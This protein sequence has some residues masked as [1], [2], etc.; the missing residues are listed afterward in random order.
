VKQLGA[1]VLVLALAPQAPPGHARKIVLIAGPLDSHPQDT[2]E[3]ERTI[4]LL[5]HCMESS[6]VFRGVRVDLVFGGWPSDPAA[7][8][9]AD[10]ILLTSGGCDRKLEDHPLY[11]GDHLQCLERQ[12]KRGCGIIFLHW[13]TFH[14]SQHHDLITEA[15]GGYF[16]FETGPP[17][18]R[19][20]SR[21][22]TRDW[23][24]TIGAPDHPIS[25]GVKPFALKE[26][27]YYRLRFRDE[28]PRLRF[29]LLKDGGEPRSSA[30]GWA[31]ERKDGGRG[32]GFTG[33]H[34][35]ANWW[36]P[37]FRRL[38]LNA[39]AWTAKI[40]VPAGG[41][42]SALEMPARARIVTGHHHPAHDWKATTAALI[43]VLEQDPR[44]RLEVTEDPEDLAGARLNGVDLVVL[45][46][47]NWEKPG[48]SNAAKD[49]FLNYL[50]RGGGLVVM[51]GANGA[52][53]GS[54]VPPESDWE[55]YRT[56]IVRRAWVS[57]KSG[58]D[59]YGPFRVE[60]SPAPHGITA[61][62]S[63]FDTLDELY[64]NQVG[65]LPVEILATA[66]SK[67]T[68]RDE[69]LALAYD[70]ETARVFQTMLGHAPE[71]IRKAG[72]LI[73][74]GACWA[75]GRSPLG[76]DPPLGLLQNAS[77][78][79]GSRWTDQAPAGPPMPKVPPPDP[80][81]RREPSD[82]GNS[83]DGKG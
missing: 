73:R 46:Y 15:V 77:F 55:E 35:F 52:W 54:L 44:I 24:T 28:D 8:D 31:V 37:D 45:N 19:W 21:I 5:K 22:E 13:S 83:K 4:V 9:D 64:Y 71:S 34:F 30:V 47:C 20:A 49:G 69:P 53:N 62:L 50:R 11:V 2:H 48:L 42:E 43:H 32:F 65:R 14:P 76:F 80:S 16:D 72:A 67:T 63:S 33:G 27:F 70:Y 78:R 58:H 23:S 10:S 38:V 1:L 59:P 74:R 25:R 29:I 51:H 57:P 18:S 39:L 75:A 3:Y 41:V 79:P 40:E 7:L 82:R 12:M 56:K 26:E 36:L 6:D 61:G 81:P 17:P 68:G 66:R 60:I